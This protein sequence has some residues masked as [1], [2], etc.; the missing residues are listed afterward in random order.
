MASGKVDPTVQAALEKAYGKEVAAALKVGVEGHLAAH[1]AQV[2][3][4]TQEVHNFFG[5]QEGWTAAQQWAKDNLSAD[6]KAMLSTGLN[7]GGEAMKLALNQLKG[8]MEQA[9]QTVTGTVL[10][11]GAPVQAGT[12][13]I[14]FSEYIKEKQAASRR[15]DEQAI[16]TL[17]ARARASMT[18]FTQRGLRWERS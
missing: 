13:E 18:S 17:E 10:T 1:Q 16:K 6:V 12:Q 2:A 7:Q 8:L 4:A 14:K 3:A 15:G 11:P 5:G 9:G